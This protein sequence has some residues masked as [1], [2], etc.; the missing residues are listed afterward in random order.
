MQMKMCAAVQEVLICFTGFAFKLNTGGY[1]LIC[2]TVLPPSSSYRDMPII[3]LL[4]KRNIMLNYT[5]DIVCSHKLV[6][7]SIVL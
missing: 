6:Y 7:Y 3:G 1:V 2:C 4:R 5:V